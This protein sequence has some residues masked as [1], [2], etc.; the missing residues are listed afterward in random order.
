MIVKVEDLQV[1]DNIIVG[2]GSKLKFLTVVKEPVKGAK[3]NKD[4]Y[5]SVR[6]SV[7]VIKRTKTGMNRW[8]HKSQ[9]YVPYVYEWKEYQH[10]FDNHNERINIDLNYKDIY[11][12]ERQNN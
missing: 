2:A 5:K 9:S 7:N 1:G 11:L 10:T 8:D 3:Y 12:V 4:H 6:C